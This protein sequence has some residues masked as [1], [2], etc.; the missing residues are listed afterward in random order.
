[1][2]AVRWGIIGC[3]NVTEVK[4]GPALQKAEG[5]SLVAVM[6]RNGELAEDYARRHDVPRWYDDA[7]ALID[8]PEVNAVYVATPPAF[9]KAYTLMSAR[10][11][12]PVYVEKPMA[13]NYAECQEM[14]H[15]C[16][17]TG[18]PLY[19]AYYRR[20][21]PRFLKVRE[22]VSSGAIGEVRFVTVT[23]YRRA[24]EG[25]YGSQNLPWRL[26]PE[27]AGGGLF[28]D[29]ACHT[30]D[31]LDY[32]LGPIRAVRGSA[33][34]QGGH[35]DAEDIVTGSLVF[36]S[37]VHGVG[38]W[39]FTAY[40]D[41]DVNE[42][43]GSAGK[44]RFSTFGVEP[45]V[46]ETMDGVTEYPIDNPAHVQQPLIQTVVDDLLGRGTCPST[47]ESAART[48]WVMDRLLEGYRNREWQV[49]DSK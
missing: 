43:V 6:R 17:R 47:G 32:A 19:V 24:R 39:C 34:N 22:L 12:K 8:D 41:E 20:G 37:G 45:V 33:S 48:S 9:H 40:R 14:I 13:L 15:V 5:S 36:E 44:L 2:R 23:L 10:A 21:L 38:A 16:R 28:A 31:F 46:L 27:I 29:L 11:G 42:I 35:Y 3:G 30:L 7:Q 49:A 26:V 1:M 4:S 25:G 18:V